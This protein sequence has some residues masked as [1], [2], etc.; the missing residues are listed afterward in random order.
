MDAS[1]RS[2]F[3]SNPFVDWHAEVSSNFLKENEIEKNGTIL[4]EATRFKTIW[5]S[6][7][8]PEK[9]QEGISG[10]SGANVMIPSA[11]LRYTAKCSILGRIGNQDQASQVVEKHMLAM[12][13]DCSLLIKSKDLSTGQVVCLTTPDKERS[14][15]THLGA[16]AELNEADII[17]VQNQLKEYNHI[18]MEGYIFYSNVVPKCLEIASKSQATLSLNLPTYNVVKFLRSNLEK[19]LSHFHY[20]F[21]N[22]EEFQTLTCL[23]EIE[24]ALATFDI[25]QTVTATDGA[26]GCWVKAKGD[27]KVIHYDTPQIDSDKIINKTGAGDIWA[28]MYLALALQNESVETCVKMANQAAGDWIQRKPGTYLDATIWEIYKKAIK[29]KSSV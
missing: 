6:A 20:I 13:V 11:M 15:V 22:K 9:Q 21:G 24:K 29:L 26:N 8:D 18:H 19:N 7:K 3:I 25:D 5:E 23:E 2:V 28:G 16:T 10:G 12:G 4:V 27:K 17:N 1:I 14:M